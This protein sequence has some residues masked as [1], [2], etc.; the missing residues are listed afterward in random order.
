MTALFLTADLVFSSRASSAGRA[1]GV[2][3]Q[4]TASLEQFTSSAQN[5]AVR[6]ILVDLTT[7]GCDIKAIAQSLAGLPHASRVVA[8]APHVMNGV[9]Q[10][11]RDAGCAQVL[12]RGQFHSQLETIIAG[13]AAPNGTRT[14]R[15]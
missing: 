5:A 1:A 10:A 8:Y 7:P 3:V 2:T 6:L 4:C 9:L 11:A 15:S 12:T 14:I 13:L